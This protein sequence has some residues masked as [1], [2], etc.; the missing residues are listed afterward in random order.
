MTS[1]LLLTVFGIV[2]CLYCFSFV[3]CFVFGFCVLILLSVCVGIVHS[4][5]KRLST[6]ALKERR[7][8]TEYNKKLKEQLGIGLPD[9][10]MENN[11]K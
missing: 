8:V 2:V 6:E 1:C 9:T 7:K 3:L 4:E 11:M 10:P 5:Q